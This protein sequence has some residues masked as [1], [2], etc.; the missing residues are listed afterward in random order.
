VKYYLYLSSLCWLKVR[1][2]YA[3]NGQHF[4]TALYSLGTVTSVKSEQNVPEGITLNL[5]ASGQREPYT[6]ESLELISH[7]RAIQ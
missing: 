3:H 7:K 6:L 2:T 1:S 4:P 5:L